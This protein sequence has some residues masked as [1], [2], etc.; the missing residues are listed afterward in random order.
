MG[1]SRRESVCFG[2]VKVRDADDDNEEFVKI[3]IDVDVYYCAW[4]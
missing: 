3:L 1:V 2:I 4:I